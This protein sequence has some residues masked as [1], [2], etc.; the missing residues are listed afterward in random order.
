LA[1]HAY[2]DLIERR[3]IEIQAGIFIKRGVAQLKRSW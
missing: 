3:A 2:A 1:A